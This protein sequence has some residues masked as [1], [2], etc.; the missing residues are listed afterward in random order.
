M[1]RSIVAPSRDQILR[2]LSIAREHSA[3]RGGRGL[4]LRALI[5][6]SGYRTL[7]P[8]IG[9]L[10]LASVLRS[11]SEMVDEWLAYS[12]DKR[13]SFGWGFGPTRDGDWMVDGPDGVH[14]RFESRY[15]GCAD[16]VLRELD[17]WVAIEDA[18]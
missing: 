12:E 13:T 17:F 14:E 5:E 16:F 8:R 1:M 15:S 2:V 11:T 6:G 3:T 10:Q 18:P 9:A 4:S 7:R